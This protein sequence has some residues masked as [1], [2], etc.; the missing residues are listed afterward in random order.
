MSYAVASGDG[1]V[2][3]ANKQVSRSCVLALDNAAVQSQR[4]VL[5]PMT[6]RTALGLDPEG[7]TMSD[8]LGMINPQ[9][10]LPPWT[11]NLRGFPAAT[12][13]DGLL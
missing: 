1:T 5:R 3:Q 4:A 9:G 11:C 6:R 13:I 8:I 7:V 2:P 10:T 12:P